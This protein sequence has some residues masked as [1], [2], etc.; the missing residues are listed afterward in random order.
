MIFG[1]T[2]LQNL[3]MCAKRARKQQYHFKQTI[4]ETIVT[5]A[6]VF[7]EFKDCV[8]TNKRQIRNR[9]KN[10]ETKMEKMLGNLTILKETYAKTFL[11]SFAAK[12]K[13]LSPILLETIVVVSKKSGMALSNDLNSS[14]KVDNFIDRVL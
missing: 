1:E 2:N 12:A 5:S 9:L 13:E 10:V 4:R 14:S 6:G 7:S 11:E 8:R 3:A